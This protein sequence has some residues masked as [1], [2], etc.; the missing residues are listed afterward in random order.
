MESEG[1]PA[2]WVDGASTRN[3]MRCRAS[4]RLTRRKHHC[5][6]CGEVVCSMCTKARQV[7]PEFHPTKRQRVCYSCAGHASWKPEPSISRSGTLQLT[8][9]KTEQS[10]P[11]IA[12]LTGPVPPNFDEWRVLGRLEVRIVEARGLIAADR[13]LTGQRTSS[14]PYCVLRISDGPHVR[15][16]TIPETLEPRWFSK[17]SFLISRCDA[18]LHISVFDE[19]TFESDDPMGTISLPLGD[20][21]ASSEPFSGWVQLKPPE[22]HVGPAGAVFVELQLVE[23]DVVRHLISHV[24][25]PLPPVPPPPAFDIDEAYG[26]LMHVVDL[27]W[28]RFLRKGLL[29]LLDLI[30]WTSPKRSCIAL[31]VWNLAARFCLAH[32]PAAL[33]AR[34]AIYMLQCRRVVQMHHNKLSNAGED[35]STSGTGDKKPSAE[36]HP[37][38]AHL[39]GMVRSLPF[40]T[41]FKELCVFLQPLLRT[42]ADF[43]QLAHDV[44]NWI[45]PSSPHMFWCSVAMAVF[46]ELAQFSTVLMT[47]GTITLL[48][49]SPLPTALSGLRTYKRWLFAT[50]VAP[51]AWKFQEDYCSSWSSADYKPTAHVVAS[52]QS[53]RS[54]LRA[55]T[56][57]GF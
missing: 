8:K 16:R 40:P 56:W 12:D 10:P 15:T 34:I 20:L 14:D 7:V 42:M 38:E 13:S 45:H 41:W 4:F 11:L 57:A 9:E 49:K 26:P 27:L 30:F 39:S 50:R 1:V 51:T 24:Y 3:C 47:V 28:S 48:I 6:K 29:W 25:P 36:K 46:C 2:P 54:L 37:E 43:L 33:F 22:G 19:D 17:V 55:R 23:F 31:L 53:H 52:G 18:V 21:H 5:R 32:W 44:F 35:A